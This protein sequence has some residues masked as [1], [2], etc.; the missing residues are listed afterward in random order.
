M[1]IEV[2]ELVSLSSRILGSV[3]QSDLIWGHSSARDPDGRGV[4]MKAGRWGW[5]RSPPTASNW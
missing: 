5:R 2:R 1:N 3:D 4:G